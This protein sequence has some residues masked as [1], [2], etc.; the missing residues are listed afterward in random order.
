MSGLFA[1]LL[2]Q[3][4]GDDLS[5]LAGMDRTAFVDEVM[6]EAQALDAKNAE[7]ARHLSQR[8]AGNYSVTLKDAPDGFGFFYG[9]FVDESDNTYR[10]D[11][12]PPRP[13]WTG[14]LNAQAADLTHWVVYLN[15][16]EVQRS[17]TIDGL[18]TLT[19]GV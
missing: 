9:S 2:R 3:T 7:Y 6:R 8:L 1:K 10:V 15:G 17:E 16:E 18:S 4:A 19:I 14:D 13:L 5:R 12:M 11:V